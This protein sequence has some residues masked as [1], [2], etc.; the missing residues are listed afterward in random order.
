MSCAENR[1]FQLGNS[2]QEVD[3]LIADYVK[4]GKPIPAHHDLTK[5]GLPTAHVIMRY[6]EH[7]R[8]P[9][10][11]FQALYKKIGG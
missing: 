9:F 2:K 5:V 1:Y 3:D 6:Y 7:W 10:E 8:E 11:M 4:N